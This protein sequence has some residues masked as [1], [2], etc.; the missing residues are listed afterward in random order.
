[1]NFRHVCEVGVYLPE[2]SNIADFIKDGIRATLVEADVD[3]VEK[4]KTFFIGC[5][6]EIF[7]VA[8]WDY[9]GTIQLSKAAASTFVTK[10][11]SSPAIINDKYKIRDEDTFEV[12]CM[13]FSE[14]DDGTIDLLSIDIEGSEWYVLKYLK[15]RP[16]VISV[17]TH[18]KY[19][20]NPFIGELKHWM[21]NEN[22]ILWYIDA[23]DTV[24]VHKNVFVPNLN[25]KIHNQLAEWKLAWKKF[26]RVFKPRS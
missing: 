17:E 20:T 19:Y 15:S 12:P 1:M 8:V 25:D 14:I 9:N 26:K 3:K 4:I 11:A 16:A 23:S 7:P 18:G 22:Y 24:F 2:T 5:N 21:A 13:I 6:I 10:L